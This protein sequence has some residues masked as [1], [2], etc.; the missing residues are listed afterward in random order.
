MGRYLIFLLKRLLSIFVSLFFISLGSFILFRLLP[1]SPFSEEASLTPLV[2]DRLNQLYGFDQNI[3]SQF[4]F[5]LRA[6]VTEGG[7]LS[8]FYNVSA[9]T[10]FQQRMG[11]TFV[12]AMASLGLAASLSYIVYRFLPVQRLE[13]ISRHVSALTVSVPLLFF[14]PILIFFVARYFQSLPV[15]YKP[16]DYVSLGLPILLLSLRPFGILLRLLATEADFWSRSF[17]AQHF[18]GLG[19]AEAEL[20]RKWI[21]KLSL[22]PV[23]TAFVGLF[24]SLL[25]GSLLTETFFSIPG[26]A[27]SYIQALLTRDY[28]VFISWTIYFAFLI[29]I[30]QAFFDLIHMKLDP[31]VE[32]RA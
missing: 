28:P 13:M 16:A 10:L 14:A 19:F 29:L 8:L 12:L 18:R 20:R 6:L 24:S 11:I 4:I 1:G 3:V 2:Q 5:F 7:G 9:W 26:L 17:T 22:I 15:L 25:V 32:I 27:S 21:L 23:T 31:R 30:L